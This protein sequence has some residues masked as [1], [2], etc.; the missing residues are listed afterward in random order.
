MIQ[1]KQKIDLPDKNSQVLIEQLRQENKD[2]IFERELLKGAI[3]VMETDR[4]FTDPEIAY[5]TA[6]S[7]GMRTGNNESLSEQ[8]KMD[9]IETLIQFA[10]ADR[11]FRSQEQLAVKNVAKSLQIDGKIVEDLINSEIRRLS[12]MK[13]EDTFVK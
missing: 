10:C 6:I 3:R 1:M 5:L 7:S 4:R 13:P 2:L 11:D 9:I 8:S 12:A